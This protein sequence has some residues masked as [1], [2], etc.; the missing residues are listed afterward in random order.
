[1]LNLTRACLGVTFAL[2]T[3]FAL[4]SSSFQ[5]T[6]TVNGAVELDVTTGAGHIRVTPGNASTVEVRGTVKLSNDW[7]GSHE[8]ELAAV[9][10]NPPIEQTGNT[11]RL[12]PLKDEELRRHVQISYD[13][14]TPAATRLKAKSG[15]GAVSADGLQ[16]PVDVST[17][18]GAVTMSHIEG[19]VALSTG[20]GAVEIDS[21]KGQVTARTGAGAIHGK[22]IAGA[23]KANTGS[24]SV[25]LEQT[26]AGPV[27][28]HTGSGSVAVRLPQQAAFSLAAHSGWGKV[29]VDHPLDTQPAK[30]SRDVKGNVR[31]GGPLVDL[32][33]GV[34]S[35]R[36]Q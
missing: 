2:S 15:A 1:M 36:V 18:A 29:T 12:V 5:R 32:S 10:A 31:G 30:D 7:T 23:V 21:V 33:T 26:A 17:G 6:L 34:G 11:I 8:K 24:G 25:Q 16:G 28:A 19:D 9:L 22:A 13:I 20:A 14:V 4:E 3:A 35:V 27:Q